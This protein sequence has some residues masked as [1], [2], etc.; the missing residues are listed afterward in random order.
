MSDSSLRFQYG[1][2]PSGFISIVDIECPGPPVVVSLQ[3]AKL[4]LNDIEDMRADGS[5]VDA[6]H[7]RAMKSKFQGALD[8]LEV[9]LH[10]NTLDH[11]F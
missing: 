8:Y 6:E 1:I 9:C 4:I 7:Y 5:F 3:L 11:L 2:T 10:A